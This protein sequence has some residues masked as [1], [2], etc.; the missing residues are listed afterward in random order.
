ML[1][2]HAMTDV[3]RNRHY[4][5]NPQHQALPTSGTLTSPTPHPSCSL[6]NTDASTIESRW[7]RMR[8][9]VRK[10]STYL[11]SF[12]SW[13]WLQREKKKS[14]HYPSAWLARACLVAGSDTQPINNV[15][16]YSRRAQGPQSSPTA[17]QPHIERVPS[18]G[19]V[20]SQLGWTSAV[21]PVVS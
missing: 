10:V 8:H 18:V 2:L 1:T 9:K 6:A 21:S 4:I 19:M 12:W 17:S 13:Y 16:N 20:G 11:L 5:S 7:S 14:V 3:G 15:H